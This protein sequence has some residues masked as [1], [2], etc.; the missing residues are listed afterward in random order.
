MLVAGSDRAK[1]FL[2]NDRM[3]HTNGP[4]GLT[5]YML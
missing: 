2:T 1:Q 3:G 4:C 5:K